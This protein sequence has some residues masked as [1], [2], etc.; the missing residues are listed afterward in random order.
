MNNALQYAAITDRQP[1]AK[2]VNLFDKTETTLAVF[3]QIMV[4]QAM[5]ESI[6]SLK[7]TPLAKLN[8]KQ[9]INL[10][11]R[12]IQAEIYRSVNTLAFSDD[13]GQALFM[14]YS[15]TVDK[16]IDLL[17]HGNPAALLALGEAIDNLNEQTKELENKQ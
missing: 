11:Q 9:R 8:L 13:K 3:R 15:K 10:V 17:V 5:I 12:D 6:D 1:S 14:D 7:G 2:R 16:V 4:G